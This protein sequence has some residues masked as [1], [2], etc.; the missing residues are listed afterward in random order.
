[1]TF[2]SVTVVSL[3]AANKVAQDFH[4]F[5]CYFAPLPLMEVMSIDNAFIGGA[6]VANYV[7]KIKKQ[8]FV[9]DAVEKPKKK[10]H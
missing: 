1:M 7:R 9:A 10:K 2:E 5:L 8:I 4:D 3:D 6:Q